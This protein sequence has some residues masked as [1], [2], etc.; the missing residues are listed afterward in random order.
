MA[1]ADCGY[2]GADVLHCVVDCEARCYAAARGVYVEADGF[3]GV[4]G[5]EEEELGDDGGRQDFFDFA[6]EADYSLFQQAGEDV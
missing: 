2:R 1:E 3:G 4:V 6:V 5:F